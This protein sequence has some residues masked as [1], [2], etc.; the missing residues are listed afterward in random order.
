WKWFV[1]YVCAFGKFGLLLQHEQHDPRAEPA[2]RGIGRRG[3]VS[4]GKIFV[5]KFDCRQVIRFEI[6]DPVARFDA[7]DGA[8][9]DPYDVARPE[10]G[11]LSIDRGG[12]SSASQFFAAQFELHVYLRSHS[13]GRIKIG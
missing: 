12:L 2:L 10:E 5:V 13:Y 11:Y 3:R 7:H 8:I 6:C 4:P 9:L 1:F